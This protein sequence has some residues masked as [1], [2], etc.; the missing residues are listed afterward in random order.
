MTLAAR[1]QIRL[2]AVPDPEPRQHPR[3]DPYWTAVVIRP[4][5]AADSSALH[6]L[7][8]LDSARHPSGAMVVAEQ[9]GS[10]VAAVSLSDGA[11]IADPFRATA[12]IVGLLQMRRGQLRRAGVP[13]A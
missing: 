10:M 1:G 3:A 5:V 11:S 9:A 13:A 6:R 2:A 7:A 4:A 12:D 8:D